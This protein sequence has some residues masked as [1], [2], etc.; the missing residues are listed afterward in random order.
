[1][2][3]PESL[4]DGRSGAGLESDEQLLSRFTKTRD[5]D[6]REELATRFL[7]LA[8]GLAARYRDR[9]ES[10][11]D[12][13][14]VARLGLLKA[15]DGYDA[16]RANSFGAYATPTILGELRRHF[17]DR[18][19]S[20][21]V[22]RDLKEAMPRIRS[23]IADLAT[24]KGRMPDEQEVAEATNME[25]AAVRDAMAASSAAR[26]ASLDAP[27]SARMAEEGAVPLVEQVGAVDLH[28]DQVEYN[29][30]LEQR[31][32][33]LSER[34]REVLHLSFVEDLTQAEIGQRVGVSQMQISRILRSSLERLRD[35]P[36]DGDA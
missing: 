19:W 30:M 23:A 2:N 18:S 11:D 16:T 24:A 3:T 34:D 8:S 35:H 22:P 6:V 17:R 21:R 27:A 25:P 12:L 33:E 36:G 1:M 20:M 13:E 7:P 5:Q 10:M 4:R 28:L 26:P 9:G 15:I 32:V 14:Q 29:V 31:L